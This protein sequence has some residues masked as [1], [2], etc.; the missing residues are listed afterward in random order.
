VGNYFINSL[1]YAPYRQA[2]SEHKLDASIWPSQPSWQYDFRIDVNTKGEKYPQYN[3]ELLLVGDF[4]LKDFLVKAAV[5]ES[6]PSCPL[7]IREADVKITFVSAISKTALREQGA[8]LDLINFLWFD[9]TSFSIDGAS[10]EDSANN[11]VAIVSSSSGNSWDSA[12]EL[13]KLVYAEDAAGS[14][15][16][17]QGN[18]VIAIQHYEKAH[19]LLQAA[20]QTPTTGPALETTSAEYQKVRHFMYDMMNNM[21]VGFLRLAKEYVEACDW[22]AAQMACNVLAC[23]ARMAWLQSTGSK[24]FGITEAFRHL[25]EAT[26]HKMLGDLPAAS[27]AI[28]KAYERDLGSR[29]IR[30]Q[31]DE[32]KAAEA[33]PD[34]EAPLQRAE[35]HVYVP[36]GWPWY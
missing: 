36:F 11:T 29:R 32:I 26:A 7:A 20:T 34:W 27:K 12:R 23:C 16:M 28:S 3:H 2:Y 13:W 31:Y 21:S 18:T 5:M 35:G 17:K 25:Q 1:P 9:F 30:E 24:L 19:Y 22:R 14:H 8:I 33:D 10:D 4:A 15:A 6:F